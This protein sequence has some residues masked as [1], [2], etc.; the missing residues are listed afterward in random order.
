MVDDGSTDG[1]AG[2][3]ARFEGR[4]TVICQR[5]R[6]VAAALNRGFAAAA[7]DFVAMTGAD[8][9]W[10]PHKLEWQR[11]ALIQHPEID[12]SF[13]HARQFERSEREYARPPGTGVLDGR[14]LTEAMYERNLIAA[15]SSLIRRELHQ[16]LGGFAEGTT[17]EDYE[18]WMRALRFGACFHYDQRLLVWHR[19]H[20]GNIS[21][22]LLEM[23]TVSHA[24]HRLYA[25]DVQPKLAS[26]VLAGDLRQIASYHI[27][28]GRP[29]AARRAF[30]RSLAF[31]RD[32]RGVV[33]AA[34]LSV[35]GGAR[36]HCRC[37]QAGSAPMTATA[38]PP[39]EARRARPGV[40][41]GTTEPRRE[42]ATDGRVLVALTLLGAILTALTWRTWG[43]PQID[44]SFELTIA[45]LVANGQVP[46]EDVRYYYGPAGL[47]ALAIGFE[48]FGTSLTTAFALGSQ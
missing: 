26:R 38:A 44:P 40:S 39:Q 32:M 47:Y 36:A 3:L 16:E 5:N 8:D 2:V 4:I 29:R 9:L 13:G 48:L 19:Q 27:A 46:Y 15:P 42:R 20:G 11:G 33:G 23:R 45:D 41:V 1:T 17:S 22:R 31:R 6:G 37:A 12:I 43:D 7:G 24:I 35:P 25:S 21:S 34:A 10:E 30:R 14:V 18:F 28:E